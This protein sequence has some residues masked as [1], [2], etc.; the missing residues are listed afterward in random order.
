MAAVS[1]NHDL[2]VLM[3]G[4]MVVTLAVILAVVLVILSY[5]ARRNEQAARQEFP[6]AQ[7]IESGALFFGQKSR[8]AGQL[9]GNGTLVFTPTELVFK[10]WVVGREFRIPY[11][12]IE[13]LETPKSFL[14]KS[15]FVKLLQVNYTDENRA[16]DAM[17]WRVK[18]LDASMRAIEE[19]IG[20]T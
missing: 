12:N 2:M 16:K 20:Q 10:Q 18:D 6:D 8:G 14:G 5:L 17:A 11:R 15:Q 19:R 3:V 1:T 9:R 7:R 4:G 13:S